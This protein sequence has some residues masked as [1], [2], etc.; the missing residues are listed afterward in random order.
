MFVDTKPRFALCIVIVAQNT[1]LIISNEK[2]RKD[3]FVKHKEFE[4]DRLYYNKCDI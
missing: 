4:G 1:W 2:F 3:H